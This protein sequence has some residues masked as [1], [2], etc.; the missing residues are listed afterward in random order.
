MGGGAAPG[1]G[2]RIGP[3]AITQVAAALEEMA[4]PDDIDALFDAAGLAAYRRAPPAGMVA[5]QEVAALHRALRARL[6]PARRRMVAWE[7]GRRTGDYLLAH[8]IPRPARW[9]LRALPPR[10]A[11]RT[12][13]AAIR[14]HAWTFAGSGQIAARG[15]R[16]VRI[17]LA[18]CPLCRGLQA[19][20][21]ACTYFAATFERLFAALV[22]PRA[23]V[24]ETECEAAG[25]AACVF[26]I[27]W[28]R[29]G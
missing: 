24:I 26:E 25:A 21:P 17:A 28:H 1:G 5:E 8:R 29:G 18:G 12:L 10:L 2:G 16:P 11:S 22:H 13:L 14:R 6:D 15:G 9:L 20:A 27:R 19:E 3:N 7:A 4:P 23:R